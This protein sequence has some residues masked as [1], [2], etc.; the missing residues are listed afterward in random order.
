MEYFIQTL[1]CHDRQHLNIDIEMADICMSVLR[2]DTH[3]HA[4]TQHCTALQ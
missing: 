1:L 4:H 2:I 3:T